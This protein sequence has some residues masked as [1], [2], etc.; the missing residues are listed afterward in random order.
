L[1]AHH[2]GQPIERIEED[3]ERDFFMSADVAQEYGLIDRVISRS[4]L[5]QTA[6]EAATVS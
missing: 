5:A 2:T 4:A 3:T 6:I 1:L